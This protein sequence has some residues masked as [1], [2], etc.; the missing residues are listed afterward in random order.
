MRFGSTAEPL[1]WYSSQPLKNG[2][3]TS[4]FW[5]LPSAVR[6]NAPLR[7]PTRTLTW[8][9]AT[10][11]L[12][13]W[14][15]SPPSSVSPCSQNRAAEQGW[16]AV[17]VSDNLM[18][19]VGTAGRMAPTQCGGAAPTLQKSWWEPC[20]GRELAHEISYGFDADGVDD[21]TLGPA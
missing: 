5:R 7:V 18:H 2:P 15:C 4:H 21:R 3:A 19:E 12:S 11:L 1:R 8:L 6:M 13:E 9:I 16:P 17:Q 14:N 10:S 20:A